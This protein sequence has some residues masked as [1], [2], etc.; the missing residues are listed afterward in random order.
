MD[1]LSTRSISLNTYSTSETRCEIEINGLLGWE[2]VLIIYSHDNRKPYL[3]GTLVGGNTRDKPWSFFL[4]PIFID[5]T[6]IT[7]QGG[8][9]G[10]P[11]KIKHLTPNTNGRC[12]IMPLGNININERLEVKAINYIP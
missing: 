11:L 8:D 4:Q 2:P 12:T 3:I 10:V 5:D 9:Y 1:N 7:I 6:Y